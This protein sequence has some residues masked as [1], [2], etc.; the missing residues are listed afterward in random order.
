LSGV[1]INTAVGATV[2]TIQFIGHRS[3][4]NGENG[5][6]VYPGPLNILFS[7]C[8]G[9]GNSRTTPSTSAGLLLLGGASRFQIIG[10]FYAQAFTFANR[11]NYGI[12]IVGGA[13]DNYTII[14]P[15]VTP[16]ATGGLTDGG[17]GLNRVIQLGAGT[18]DI[19]ALGAAASLD[20]GFGDEQTCNISGN[21]PITT[22]LRGWKGRRIRLFKTDAGTLTIGGGG[23]IPLAHS[24]VQNGAIDLV[25]DGNSWF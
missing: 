10:G 16:N 23:N 11:Q 24:L 12:A 20:L 7:D 17:T 6:M 18:V 8:Q 2:N 14:G 25:F 15:V 19:L 5:Y 3:Y 4:N 1:L 9:I 22:I 13:S 21:T